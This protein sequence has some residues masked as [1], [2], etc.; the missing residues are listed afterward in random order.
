M[1]KKIPLVIILIFI[2]AVFIKIKFSIN[3]FAHRINNFSYYEFVS[4]DPGCKQACSTEYIVNSNGVVLR[5]VESNIGRDRLVKVNIGI[6][7]KDKAQELILNVKTLVKA[8]KSEA[9]ESYNRRLVHI[10]FSDPDETKSV[11]KYAD[12]A[13]QWISEVENNTDLALEATMPVESFYINFVS[14]PQKGNSLSYHFF[15]DG[16]ILREEF[17]KKGRQLISAKAYSIDEKEISAIK[18]IIPQ[19]Y[20]NSSAGEINGCRDSG[21]EWGYIGIKKGG[22]YKVVYTCGAGNNI[23]DNLFKALS[24]KIKEKHL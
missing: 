3:N 22:D 24:K 7:A 5:K 11:T 8:F 1:R 17:T 21:L 13:P 16:T 15:P 19:A 6:I 18:E 2:L 12:D 20:F 4:E 9:I 23:A 10:L 14:V